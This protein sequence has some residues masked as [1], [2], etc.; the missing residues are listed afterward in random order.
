MTPAAGDEAVGAGGV[1]VATVVIAA[2]GLAI[3]FA[4]SL[5]LAAAPTFTN[6]FWFHLKMGEV[7]WLEGLW[8]AAD[9]ML[10]TALPDAPIQHE[11]LFGV[12]LFGIEQSFGFYGVRVAHALAVG[13][14]LWL[15]FAIAR[16][17]G[18]TP[19][20]ACLVVV[21]LAVLG[22]TRFFQ[23]RPDLVSIPATLAI[24]RLL[25]ARHRPPTRREFLFFVAMVFVWAN[26]HSLFAFAP[27]L[28]I[29]AL[30]GLAVRAVCEWWLLDDS[31]HATRATRRIALVLAV[32]FVASIVI[33]LVN[34]RGIEQ[35]LTFLSSSRDTAIWAVKDEWTHFDPFVRT[36]NPGSVSPLM[37]GVMNGVIVSFALA[38]VAGVIAVLRRSKRALET[39]DPVL[40]GLGLAS[41][42]AIAVSVR[43]LWM[44]FFP[45]LF[46]ARALSRVD[47]R[48]DS[49][50]I[51]SWAL[52]LLTLAIS[53]Q[54]YRA[55]GY[56]TTASRLPQAFSAYVEAPY[57]SRKFYVEGVEFLQASGATGKL[58]NSYG[59]GGFLGYWL[60]PKMQ[61]FIDS[62]TEHYP[63]DVMTDY[64][65]VSRMRELGGKRSYLGILDRR[66]VDFFFGVGMPIGLV[67][68]AGESTTG[69]L[70]GVPGWLPV[71]RSLRHAI[72]L[73][74]VPRNQGNLENIVRYYAQAGVPFDR[75]RGFSTAAVIEQNPEWAL[76]HGLMTTTQAADLAYAE[77]AV[78]EEH[79]RALET[80]AL[81]YTLGGSY[82]EA[83]RV[84]R[85]LAKLGPASKA[86]LMRQVYLATKLDLP[87]LALKAAVALP[88]EGDPRETDRLLYQ[89]L[90][91]AFGELSRV[92]SG[93]MDPGARRVALSRVTQRIPLLSKLQVALLERDLA[94]AT[95]LA[96]RVLDQASGH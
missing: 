81:I 72:Y 53:V 70:D 52:A 63:P 27:L 17:A 3:A 5:H 94:S 21:V 50:D 90:A 86:S 38:C 65:R 15:G 9:P 4:L 48:R 46:V 13:A 76:R 25:L 84:E 11:W 42:V 61:T 51:I 6:D 95:R 33:S 8:P 64:S 85:E 89:Q 26:A 20:A 58:F 19:V 12:F 88:G 79:G 54:F 23:V 2:F 30:L 55:S 10:H 35:H 39:F 92:T 82:D 93:R 68:K 75:R 24:Y 77:S 34:P 37:W 32:A 87:D 62:R 36:N 14:T 91:I 29:A 44:A 67:S 22:W 59:M 49:R 71:S 7:Y 73:R 31:A 40:L 69:H 28:L 96:P 45:A 74:D 56:S 66:G 16:R 18:A 83:L 43:F 78:A 57:L 60:S 80:S 41:I 1:P 47:W